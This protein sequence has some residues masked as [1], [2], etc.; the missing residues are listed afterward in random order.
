MELQK[1]AQ[2]YLFILLAPSKSKT[3]FINIFFFWTKRKVNTFQ[4]IEMFLKFLFRSFV[5]TPPFL[6]FTS[7]ERERK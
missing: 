7:R 5:L 2:L 1:K 6:N 4:Y 3:I